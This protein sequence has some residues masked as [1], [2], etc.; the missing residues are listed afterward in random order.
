[1]A[2]NP[3]EDLFAD[4][5]MTFGEHL[6]ELRQC[7]FRAAIGLVVGVGFG[8]FLADDVIQQIQVPLK[9]SLRGYYQMQAMDK[10]Q[11]DELAKAE[12]AGL[13]TDENYVSNDIEVELDQLILRLKAAVPNQLGALNYS[14]YSFVAD[15]FYLEAESGSEHRK[16]F[17]HV[18]SSLDEELPWATFLVGLLDDTQLEQFSRVV[19]SV[20]NPY[21]EDLSDAVE[22]LNV[23]ANEASVYDNHE[24]RD[25]VKSNIEGPDTWW[26]QF[27]TS[28]DENQVDI[29]EV[30]SNLT[31]RI[32][33]PNDGLSTAD[34]TRRINKF[35]ISNAFPDYLRSARPAT[36]TLPVWEKK[37]IR[38]QT[39]NAHEGF[40]IWLKA[41]FIAGFVI[42]SP[43]IFFQLWAFV[44]AGL[45][46][47][48]RKYVYIYLPFCLALFFGGAAM[49][50]F[51]V[52]EPVLDFLFSY[53]R[54]MAIDPDPRISEWLGFVMFLPIG[55]GVAFQLPLVMLM[56]QRI[57]M[58]T[59][60]A[61]LAKWRVAILVIFIIAM[62]LTPADPLSMLL[63][64]GP[65]TVLY[66]L[67]ILLCKF[68][69]RNKNP[70]AESYD[71]V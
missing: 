18:Q 34:M 61:Y 24:I 23:W 52:M 40:M 65:L 59:T 56:L 6:E 19:N 66:F 54:M 31:A 68:M 57:G 63:L 49:A 32:N 44:A 38:V 50:F 15:D 43:W 62:F 33:D 30:F 28:T 51:I 71:P 4:S 45:Y 26:T 53:N 37:D 58:F 36:I 48:E 8:L 47:H 2:K 64:G 42:G 3:K 35:A 7:L 10:I 22:L 12:Q 11:N 20:D 16:F 5:T 67:G 55:F 39:L 29:N 14:P 13:I 1:M 70:Y 21:D 25:L 9:K 27:D 69:P 41:A 46:P 17:Q 60:A